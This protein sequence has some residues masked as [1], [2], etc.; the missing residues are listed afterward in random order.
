M[1]EGPFNFE[2]ITDVGFHIVVQESD[3]LRPYRV[4]SSAQVRDLFRDTLLETRR[5]LVPEGG[6]WSEFDP[7]EKYSSKDPIRISASSDFAVSF[8]EIYSAQNFP[9]KDNIASV[10]EDIVYYF[11]VFRDASQN[12][13]V[14]MRKAT[15]LRALAKAKDRTIAIGLAGLEVIDK[16]IFK[17]DID[18]DLVITPDFVYILRPEG[19]ILLG[20][21]E[22]AVRS[23]AIASVDKLQDSSSFLDLSKLKGIADR[24]NAARLIAAIKTRNDI[25]T[26]NK[27]KFENLASRV[28][29]PLI[30]GDDGRLG[31]HPDRMMD[32][33]KLLDY[34][35]YFLDIR[36]GD[37]DVYEAA[38]R[39]QVS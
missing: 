28:N 22:R 9:P 20:D 4:P 26:L 12:K 16:P 10:V 31:P 37:P 17:V 14:G 15:Q 30:V 2:S 18:F 25:H 11:V 1:I 6:V 27:E 19:F 33:L 3:G 32:F 5:T 8:Y 34:R 35:R 21:V 23:S 36:D 13:I 7:S 29:V 38:S 24:H 39:K